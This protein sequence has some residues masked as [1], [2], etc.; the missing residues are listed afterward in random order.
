MTKINKSNING[1]TKEKKTL[2]KSVVGSASSPKIDLNKV[3]DEW[4]YGKSGFQC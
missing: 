4:K 2:F 1:L 3:R